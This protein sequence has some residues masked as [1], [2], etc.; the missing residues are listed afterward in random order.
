M[1][2]E[3]NNRLYDQS[4]AA[5]VIALIMMVV[6][7]L[8]GLAAIFTSTF[9]NKLSG[10]K[11]E[12]T[13]AFFVAEAGLE[14]VKAD[15]TNFDPAT[16]Y[17][18]AAGIP[19]SLSNEPIDLVRSGSP[20]INWPSGANF[21]FPP[22]VT[23]YHLRVPGEGT[24]YYRSDGYIIDSIGRDQLT[25]LLGSKCEVREKRMLRSR[26]PLSEMDS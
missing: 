2:K 15:T 5:L 16:N 9:E 20:N 17:V 10:N 19:S 1:S 8:I 26:G 23:I 22:T 14:A 11:R 4:G 12:S 6:L 21:A 7:T 3:L 24:Q 25:G 13:G 18:A